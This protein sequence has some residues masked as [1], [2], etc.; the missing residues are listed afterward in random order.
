MNNTT[1]HN[2]ISQETKPENYSKALLVFSIVFAGAFALISL[3]LNN[4]SFDNI[5]NFTSREFLGATVIALFI[6]FI[7]G[8]EALCDNKHYKITPSP[9]PEK[10]AY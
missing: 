7:A 4:G 5:W 2:N 8:T 10:V 9:L 6:A 1:N 3:C